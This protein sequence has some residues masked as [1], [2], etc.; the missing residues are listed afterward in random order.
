MLA[1]VLIGWFT[2]AGA[3]HCIPRK[4]EKDRIVCVCNSTYC[5]S[6]PEMSPDPGSFHWYVSSKAGQRL[7]LTTGKIGN[8]KEGSTILTLN[9]E[10]RYQ[11]IQGFGG[12]FTD[13]AGI[14]IKNLSDASQQKLLETYFSRTGSRYNLGRIPIGVTDFS[15][16]Y[17]SYDDI[18]NDILLENFNLAPEDTEYKIPLVQKAIELNPELL[19]LAAAWTAP[20][21]MKTTNK[22]TLKGN[23][24]EE[25]FQVF[26]DYL[27][28]FLTEY[29]KHN[30]KFWTISTGNEPLAK[31]VSMGWKSED[32]GTFIANNLGPSLAKSQHNKTMILTLDDQKFYLLSS[33]DEIF[34]NK[35]VDKFVS[36]I[37]FHFYTDIII[38]AFVLNRTHKKYPE[39]FLL[40]TEACEGFYP[41]Q[42]QKVL[43]GDWSRGESYVKKMFD[44]LNEWTTG[45]VDWNLA[46]DKDGGPNWVN[47]FVD[48]SI[49]VNPETDE[50]FK[51]PLYYVIHHFSR[52]VPRGSVRLELN[53]NSIIFHS[54][55]Y[56]AFETPQK[57]TVVLIYNK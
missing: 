31:F 2:F 46:L 28:K 32:I 39:K 15:T 13:S 44:N 21:W 14:N 57:E 33:I 10:K 16:R 4:F 7:N 12:A 5:D 35:E 11:T 45:W 56:I 52:F 43:L 37:G 36:G 54:L 40:M 55:T 18:P 9:P 27:L 26:A 17:Y 19:F 29:E 1:I 53:D 50:F 24:K 25:Y 34:E 51:Q 8:T 3:N 42:T 38:P 49:I 30:I 22:N 47:N 6:T 20:S 41:W 23:L 48:A